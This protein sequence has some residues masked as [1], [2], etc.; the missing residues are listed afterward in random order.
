MRITK[1]IKDNAQKLIDKEV[2]IK[3]GNNEISG[4]VKKVN[5]FN[6]RMY[7]SCCIIGEREFHLKDIKKVAIRQ[8]MIWLR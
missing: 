6:Y 3:A 1:R 7:V 4:T 8:K 2:I 5:L